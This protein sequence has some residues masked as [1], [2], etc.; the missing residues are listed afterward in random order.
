MGL[1]EQ[2]YT[3]KLGAHYQTH[4]NYQFFEILATKKVQ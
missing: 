1:L 3:L 4:G 2:D